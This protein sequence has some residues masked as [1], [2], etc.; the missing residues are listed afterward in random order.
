MHS[1]WLLLVP[2]LGFGAR[3][4]D[5][6]A[7]RLPADVSCRALTLPGHGETSASGF[8]IPDIAAELTKWAEGCP[9]P[10]HVVGSGI[11]ALLAEHLA[12]TA[13]TASLTVIGWPPDQRPG[14]LGK[15]ILTTQAALRQVGTDTFL[16]A[17]RADAAPLGKTAAVAESVSEDAFVGALEAAACW[18]PAPLPRGLPATLI[19]GSNDRRCRPVDVR[20]LTDLWQAE[21]HEVPGAGHATYVDAPA[22]VAR[23]L[24][25]VIRSADR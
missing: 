16:A 1:T 12:R 7:S 18:T 8:N 25:K 10:P 20:A 2:T 15:R 21:F 3:S 24:T 5:A 23:L 11:G 6:V 22:E 17:Y 9:E 14:E 19:Y 13:R 4:W